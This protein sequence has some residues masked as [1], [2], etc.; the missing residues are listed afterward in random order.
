[1]S[2]EDA[3]YYVSETQEFVSYKE[4]MSKDYELIDLTG[5]K[6]HFNNLSPY[7]INF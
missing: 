3:K 1:M 5:W 7:D 4:F 2:F 6:T